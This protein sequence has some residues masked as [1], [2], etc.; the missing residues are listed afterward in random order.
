MTDDWNIFIRT[1]GGHVSLFENLSEAKAVRIIQ[2]LKQVRNPW[3]DEAIRADLSMVVGGSSVTN[4]GTTGIIF[5]GA[6][7]MHHSG[8]CKYTAPNL[9]AIVHL[10]YWNES[11]DD[12]EIWPKP[13]DYD[14]RYAKAKAAYDTVSA[15]NKQ[16]EQQHG[17]R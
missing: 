3:T 16:L 15:V 4:W 2:S 1:S 14:E 6:N 11:G 7:Y 13:N 17:N 9:T 10:D 5:G 8:S 12:L